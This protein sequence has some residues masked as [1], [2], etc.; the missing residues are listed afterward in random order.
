M[1]DHTNTTLL[2]RA[3]KLGVLSSAAFTYRLLCNGTN[4]TPRL[5]Y[6]HSKH[7]VILVSDVI[8]L[9]LA[10]EHDTNRMDLEKA[11]FFRLWPVDMSC[12]LSWCVAAF[13]AVLHSFGTAS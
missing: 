12:R 7:T 4:Y 10:P 1:M 11:S 2:E 13:S 9:Q 3:S 6:M 8:F 5:I